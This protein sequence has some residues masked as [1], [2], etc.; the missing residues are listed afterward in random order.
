M[1]KNKVEPTPEQMKE[2]RL[3]DIILNAWYL[4]SDES[5]KTIWAEITKYAKVSN[6]D[7]FFGFAIHQCSENF[8]CAKRADE[9]D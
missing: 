9:N 4:L 5:R 6:P 3:C 1:T 7:I 2:S 8:K